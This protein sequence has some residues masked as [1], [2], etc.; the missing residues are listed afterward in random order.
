MWIGRFGNRPRAILTTEDLYSVVTL[1]TANGR[2]CDVCLTPA[3][4]VL[5]CKDCGR[6]W[7]MC[8]EHRPDVAPVPQLKRLHAAVC[9]PVRVDS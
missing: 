9:E 3:T 1:A 7:H 8:D 5:H 2:G 6:T 4:G